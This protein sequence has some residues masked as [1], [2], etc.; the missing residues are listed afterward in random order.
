MKARRQ[1]LIIL[2]SPPTHIQ[3]VCYEY[4]ATLSSLHHGTFEGCTSLSH[5]RQLSDTTN[6]SYAVGF[7]L[8]PAQYPYQKTICNNIT[9]PP[10]V[11]L[12]RY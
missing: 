12:R 5:T 8:L 11:Q 7:V 9:L 1:S 6:V 10:Q 2:R 4:S 3:S